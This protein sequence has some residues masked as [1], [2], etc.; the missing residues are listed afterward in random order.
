MDILNLKMVNCFQI[1]NP[2]FI[3]IFIIILGWYWI[4]P[5]LGMTDDAVYVFCNMTAEGET[6]LFPDIHSSTMPNIPWRKENDKDDWYSNLRGGFRITYETIG[7]VQ[8]TFLRLLSQEGYQNFTYSC[9]NSAAWFNSNTNDYSTAIKLLGENEE[10][11]SYES[12]L[13]KPSILADGCKVYDRLIYFFLFI[14]YSK[15]ISIYSLEKVKVKPFLKFD[16]KSCSIFRLLIFTQL[17]MDYQIRHLDFKWDQFA[18][19]N[20]YFH[21]SCKKIS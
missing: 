18:L 5:N 1:I 7:V 17:I 16:R 19:N 20:I 11:I 13:I 9:I 8:M 21:I 4:D 12:P 14:W 15:D 10:E 6:C 3:K 2:T